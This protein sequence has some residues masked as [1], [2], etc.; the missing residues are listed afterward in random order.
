M[1]VLRLIIF[2]SVF[3]GTV[4]LS[5]ADT[6]ESVGLFNALIT[7]ADIVREFG[8]EKAVDFTITTENDGVRHFVAEYLFDR[9]SPAEHYVLDIAVAPMGYFLD[10]IL[11]ERRKDTTEAWC[12][13]SFEADYPSIGRRAQREFFGVGPG[14]AA[15]G[16]TFTTSDGRFDI[17]I[18]VSSLMPEEIEGPHFD[19]DG[20]ARRLSN[21][22]DAEAESIALKRRSKG[23]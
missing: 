14:G 15:Y 6:A 22:Y 17:R 1:H 2:L 5:W 7:K 11:Y 21:R 3:S 13:T 10:P 20:F 19:L 9:R 18:T 4:K 8:L 23:K 16:L 12:D